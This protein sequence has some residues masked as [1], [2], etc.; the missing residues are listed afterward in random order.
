MADNDAILD[1]CRSSRSFIPQQPLTSPFPTPSLRIRS[2][3]PNLS[4]RVSY[5]KPTS[6]WI[7]SPN[8]SEKPEQKTIGSSESTSNIAK[9]PVAI[10]NRSITLSNTIPDADITAYRSAS[11]VSM[12]LRPKTSPVLRSMASSPS[13]RVSPS[14]FTTSIATPVSSSC[15][16]IGICV[17]QDNSDSRQNDSPP[18]REHKLSNPYPPKLNNRTFITPGVDLTFQELVEAQNVILYNQGAQPV[19]FG[20]LFRDQKTIVI[21]IRHFL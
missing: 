6:E 13:L 17:N 4:S 18:V 7:R 11:P 5:H 8:P 10:P 9:S 12:D 19:R 3:T 21:F 14:S 20:D 1:S 16:D 2:S 15:A